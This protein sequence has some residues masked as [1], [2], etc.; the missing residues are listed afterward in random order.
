MCGA[1]RAGDGRSAVAI[2]ATF[3]A[4]FAEVFFAADALAGDVAELL[5][6]L[7]VGL[8]FEAGFWAGLSMGAF[9]GAFFELACC[10]ILMADFLAAWDE[11]E[12]TNY[13][14]VKASGSTTG[15]CEHFS[16]AAKPVPVNSRA[17]ILSR[18]R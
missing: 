12:D 5:A 18:R 15:A 13:L 10:L 6:V 17:D 9:A 1:R 4:G 11:L 7:L 8:D 2:A 14:S 3:L 16:G